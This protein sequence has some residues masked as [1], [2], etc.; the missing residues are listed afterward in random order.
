MPSKD[1]ENIYSEKII[2][3][4]QIVNFDFL[5]PKEFIFKVIIDKNFNKKWD[6]GE[7]L[8]H[9]QPEEVLYYTE[10]IKVRSNWDIEI[11]F[12]VNK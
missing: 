6:T 5:P 7:Y 4:D 1:K 9:V 3:T 2:T 10:K 12:D 11:N 8:K